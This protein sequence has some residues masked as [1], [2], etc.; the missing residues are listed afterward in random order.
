MIRINL[1]APEKA[2]KAKAKA[3]GPAM[4]PGALQSYLLLALLVGGAC[5][6]CAGAWWLQ[7]NKLRDLDTRI[8]ADEKRMRDLQAIAAQVQA[9]QQ[10][11]AILENKVLV[12]EQ[13]RLAQKSPVHMLD[14]VS[15]ALPDYVWLSSLDETKGSLRFAGQSN[16]LAAIADFISAMQRS[17]W[18]P[19]VDLAT[20]TEQA[21]LINFTL[22]GAFK[23]PEVAAKE[24]AIADAKAAAAAAAGP[25]ARP[26]PGAR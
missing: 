7:S 8:A 20:S 26:G 22:T 9:F 21:N 3:A 10:K 19:A 24:K 16:S 6:L 17:G 2:A 5:V 15:K 13:L 1:V 4:P 18:F 12:I 14:E 11:K 25:P 23:D